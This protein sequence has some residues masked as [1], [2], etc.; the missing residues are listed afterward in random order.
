M[1]LLINQL[2]NVNGTY[3]PYIGCVNDT[4][5]PLTTHH[6][7][8]IQ[9]HTNL[10][11]SFLEDL[12][13]KNILPPSEECGVFEPMVSR[14]KFCGKWFVTAWLLPTNCSHRSGSSSRQWKT[15]T[16]KM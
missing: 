9:G 1:K 7:M 2:Q 15:N 8:A 11:L 5:T 13:N 6:R 10:D 16:S 14:R 12:F 4:D 3:T